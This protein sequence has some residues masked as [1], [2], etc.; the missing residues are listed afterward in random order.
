[1][2]TAISGI[3]SILSPILASQLLHAG[4]SWRFVYYMGLVL[5]IP[6][7]LYFISIRAPKQSGVSGDSVSLAEHRDEC[8]G[9]FHPVLPQRLTVNVLH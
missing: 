4:H 8:S 9:Q 7:A 2:L 5:L 6:I 3:G 1:M